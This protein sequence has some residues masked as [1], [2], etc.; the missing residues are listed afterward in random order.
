MNRA[1]AFCLFFCLFMLLPGCAARK[2]GSSH[3]ASSV[4]K[5]SFAQGLVDKSQTALKH[6]L[7]N[8]PDQGIAFLMEN[9][10]G[11]MIFP[12]VAKFG[13][14]GSVKGGSGVACARTNRG[15]SYPVFSAMGGG[16]FGLQLGI[17]RGPVLIV[18]MSRELFDDAREGGLSFDGR[19]GFTIFN[20]SEGHDTSSLVAGVDA[21]MFVDWEGFYAGAAVGGVAVSGRAPLND[22]YYGVDN[23]SPEEILY[24]GVRTNF[25]ANGLRELLNGTRY[26][27]KK[28]DGNHVPVL[29][30]SMG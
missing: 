20:I 4:S 21:Y 27:E 14:I 7:A 10:A 23:V 17:K 11:I 2:G 16:S 3:D 13:F 6:F 19:G 29:G 26:E 24:E 30:S 1:H 18:F 15:W 12:N 9:A 22:A 5:T 8:D 28:K 25:G